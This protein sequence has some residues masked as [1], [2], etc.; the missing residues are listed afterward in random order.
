MA[1]DKAT[2]EEVLPGSGAI[3]SGLEMSSDSE[4]AA[5]KRELEELKR[6]RLEALEEREKALAI[7]SAKQSEIEEEKRKGREIDLE[8]ERNAI[9]QEQEEIEKL[10]I[11]ET[12]S[13]KDFK[14]IEE[15]LDGED[16]FK[17]IPTNSLEATSSSDPSEKIFKEENQKPNIGSIK[18]TRDG[19]K[20]KYEVIPGEEDSPTKVYKIQVPKLVDGKLSSKEFDL[21]Y[22]NRDSEVIGYNLS[23]E[24]VS[25]LENKWF[26]EKIKKYKESIG[27]EQEITSG[28]VVDSVDTDSL[29]K[30]RSLEEGIASASHKKGVKIADRQKKQDPGQEQEELD[31]EFFDVEDDLEIDEKKWSEVPVVEEKKWSEI[32]PKEEE[33]SDAFTEEE[34]NKRL[35]TEKNIDRLQ[36]MLGKTEKMTKEEVQESKDII[37]EL[38]LKDDLI[39]DSKILIDAAK[40]GHLEALEALIEIGADVNA[41]DDKG[42]TALNYVEENLEEEAKKQGFFNKLWGAI[43]NFGTPLDDGKSNNERILEALESKNA[44]N[45]SKDV[46]EISIGENDEVPVEKDLILL[47]TASLSELSEDVQRKADEW[48]AGLNQVKEVTEGK[49]ASQVPIAKKKEE[50][51]R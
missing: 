10:N 39:N 37:D 41:I 38:R 51:N 32:K 19:N 44:K 17:D 25:Q 12:I 50:H 42:K 3:I 29:D 1:K 48:S 30:K 21:I 23:N 26:D 4:V 2:E 15:S 43:Q 45:L 31:A 40:N 16:P 46:I 13:A 33:F 22:L 35:E 14:K 9:I 6:K 28:V 36:E 11:G 24:G 49:T 27:E 18:E 20:F 8:A 7:A 47:P 34:V 5:K